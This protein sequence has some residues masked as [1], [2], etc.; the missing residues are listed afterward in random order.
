MSLGVGALATLSIRIVSIAAQLG[1]FVLLARSSPIEVVGLFAI[2]SAAWVLGRALLPMGWNIAL[3]RRVAILRASGGGHQARVLLWRAFSE[4][5][6]LGAVIGVATIACVVFVAEEHVTEVALSC[7]VGV[8]WAEIGVLVAYLRG[9]GDLVWSQ[10][11]DGVVVYVV[12]LVICVCIAAFGSD[13]DI[14][15]S[16]VL[17][18]F[19]ASAVVALA[20]LFGI[21]LAKSSSESRTDLPALEIPDERRLARRL[22]WNQAF[23]ALSGRASVMLAAP[24]AGVASTA[25]V[26]AGLRTQLVG[27]TLAWAGGTVASPRYAV[28]HHENRPDGPR[29]LNIVTWCAI[30]PST[31]VVAVLVAWGEP[32]LGVLGTP[33]VEDRWAITLMAVA[34]VIEL[35]GATGGYFLMMTGRERSAS[36]STV[37]QLIVL[38]ATTVAIGPFLGALGIALAVLLASFCRTALV[39]IGLRKDGVRSP[40]SASGIVT[41]GVTLVARLRFRT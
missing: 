23:S 12:P 28:A 1:F 30:L 24:L 31:L 40:L 15:I 26:E 36:T 8:M 35:P 16:T 2:C 11:C 6:V 19:V 5:A 13:T 38:V 20:G 10:I 7:V 9:L 4:T 25:I 37:A 34:A 29:I 14:G 39:L 21:L 22:W 41:I 18:T 3:M 32:I 27:A 17:S 33:F